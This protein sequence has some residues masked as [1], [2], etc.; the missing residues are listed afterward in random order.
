MSQLGSV[1]LVTFDGKVLA[2]KHLL[3]TQN[4]EDG[5]IFMAAAP[6][7]TKFFVVV[8]K[9][10]IP[11]E[12]DRPILYGFDSKLNELFRDT[13]ECALAFS[14]QCSDNGKY[15]SLI[16][17]CENTSNPFWIMDLSGRKLLNFEN[18]RTIV[19]AA[20]SDYFVYVPRDM[21][22]EIF[23]TTNRQASYRPRLPLPKFPW[24]SAAISSDG[25]LATLYNGNDIALINTVSR[26]WSRVDFPYAFESCLVYDNGKTIILRGEFGYLVYMAAP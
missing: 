6:G 15:L 3:N 5:N 18:P 2:S 4:Y 23:S 20:G 17:E 13:L 14:P 1:S 19:F 10:A 12:T 22:P 16:E 24:T 8:N 26:S 25:S 11:E 21:D 7:E 9:Y